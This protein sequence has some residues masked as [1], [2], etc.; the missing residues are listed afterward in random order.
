M[1][2]KRVYLVAR[3]SQV[4]KNP[5]TKDRST[6]AFQNNESVRLVTS[7]KD[8]DY[9]EASVILDIGE[10]KVL[11]NRF[12]ERPFSELFQYYVVHYGDYINRWF[13]AHNQKSY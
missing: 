7:L 4:L 13:N 3:Y 9:Q 5:K 8:R 6:D 12:T 2:K 11:K 1:N 10:Q